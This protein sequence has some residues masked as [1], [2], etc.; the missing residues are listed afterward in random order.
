MLKLDLRRHKPSLTEVITQINHSMRD[1]KPSVTRVVGILLRVAIAIYI[2]AIEIARKSYLTIAS[3]L[4]LGIGLAG[5]HR[6][7]SHCRHN[8]NLVTFHEPKCFFGCKGMVFSHTTQ[9][10]KRGNSQSGLPRYEYIT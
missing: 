5:H 9:Y 10:L 3:H 2:V 6:H 4:Q 7:G 1:V 8:N